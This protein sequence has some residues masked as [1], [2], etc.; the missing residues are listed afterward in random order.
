MG[1]FARLGYHNTRLEDIAAAAGF[2]K[3]ALY[4]YY[5]NKEAIFLH[6]AVREYDRLYESIA[7]RMGEGDSLRQSLELGVRTILDL[8]G[9]HFPLLL[10]ISDMHCASPGELEPL[11]RNHRALFEELHGRLLAM[12]QLFEAM[13]AQGRERGELHSNLSDHLLATMLTAQI[14]GVLFEWKLAGAKGIIADDV[15]NVLEFVMH[16]MCA[17]RAVHQDEEAG[18]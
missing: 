2:S 8:C 13:L 14:R 18:V 11:A 6:L 17:A 4:N 15:A 1:A 9:E 12:Q 10:E 7:S 3:A 16:G 5:S